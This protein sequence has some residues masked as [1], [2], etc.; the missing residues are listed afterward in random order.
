MT[1]DQI[2]VIDKELVAAS[3]EAAIT[4]EFGALAEFLDTTIEAM[5]ARRDRSA[6]SRNLR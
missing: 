5:F 1:L 4:E 2:T 3:Y 6:L